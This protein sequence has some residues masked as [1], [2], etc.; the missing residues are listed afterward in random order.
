M[1]TMAA[2]PT[3][4]GGVQYRSRLE[5]K[6]AAFFDLVGWPYQYEPFDLD[7]W[8]PDFLLGSKVLVEV[9]PVTEF[10]QEIADEILASAEHAFSESEHDCWEIL[11]LG[12]QVPIDDPHIDCGIGWLTDGLHFW[13]EAT[14]V[15]YDGK[16]DFCHTVGS[17][18]GRI[19]GGYN[20]GSWG[21]GKIVN[22]DFLMQKWR[23]AGNR[24]QWKPPR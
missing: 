8:I 5:A 4:Y 12:C 20:G 17:F 13:G 6:W 14:L 19:H 7:G 23:E 2:I 22:Q 1:Y 16:V 24:V 9:K 11:I 15:D 18:H 3:L 21:E 10:P